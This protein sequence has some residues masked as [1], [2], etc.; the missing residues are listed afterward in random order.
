MKSFI[1]ACVIVVATCVAEA[2]TPQEIEKAFGQAQKKGAVAVYEERCGGNSSLHFTGSTAA[3]I[4]KTAAALA[5]F[6]AANGGGV[7]EGSGCAG[8]M[9]P[10]D[11]RILELYPDGT[12]KSK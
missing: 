4:A 9:H 10:G 8:G 7:Q 12:V 2:A 11:S 3:Q 5:A 1:V 6:S